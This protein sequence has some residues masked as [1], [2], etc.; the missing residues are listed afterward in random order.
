[1]RCARAVAEERSLIFRRAATLDRLEP[2][3]AKIAHVL[4]GDHRLVSTLRSA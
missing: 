2:P 3:V 4:N 1:M